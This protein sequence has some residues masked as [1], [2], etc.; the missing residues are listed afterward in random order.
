MILI[1]LLFLTLSAC[2]PFDYI[3]GLDIESVALDE[4][5]LNDV[6]YL[7]NFDLSTIQLHVIN[8]DGTEEYVSLRP[9]MFNREDREKLTREGRHTITARYRGHQVEFEIQLSTR[10]TISVVFCFFMIQ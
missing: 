10:T 2:H 9:S 5:S 3:L 8:E 4:R 7:D 6:Y 1:S